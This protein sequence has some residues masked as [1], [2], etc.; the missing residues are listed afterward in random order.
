M[1]QGAAHRSPLIA[2]RSPLE[3]PLLHPSSRS[4]PYQGLQVSWLNVCIGLHRIRGVVAE[5]GRTAPSPWPWRSQL[6]HAR[7][8]HTAITA[9]MPAS[10][11]SQRPG[12]HELINTQTR[13]PSPCSQRNRRTADGSRFARRQSL[14]PDVVPQPSCYGLHG[15][16]YGFKLQTSLWLM[17]HQQPSAPQHLSGARRCPS[18]S[19]PLAGTGRPGHGNGN[20]P[21]WLAF[22]PPRDPSSCCLFIAITSHRLGAWPGPQAPRSQDAYILSAVSNSRCQD[23]RGLPLSA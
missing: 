3:P 13:S 8:F 23:H 4:V 21:A 20:G 10:V 18:P 2:H 7:Q 14:S 17:A 12:A 9:S 19:P 6:G 16:G 1:D 15:I 11:P 5:S 22:P